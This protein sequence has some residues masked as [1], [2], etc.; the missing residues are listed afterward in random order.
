MADD[1]LTPAPSAQSVQ[2]P[3]LDALLTPE[4]AVEPTPAFKSDEFLK[5]KS[6]A[7]VETKPP[8]P[9]KPQ[10]V[11]RGG[12]G[13]FTAL[14]MSTIAAG[15][16]AYL[17]LLAGSRPDVLERVGLAK[18]VPQAPAAPSLGVNAG[19]LE[20]L[21]ARISAVEAELLSLKT[22]LDGTAPT[23]G[24]AP[25]PSQTQPTTNGPAVGTAVP[26]AP[27]NAD[28]GA[29]KAEL[30]GIAGRVTAI[31][32]RL[33]ALD[34]T[35]AGGAIV[36]GLQADIAAL[37]ATI[38]A[39]QQQAANA[40]SPAVT[41]AV[42]NLA[43][44]ANRPGPFM[45][46]YQTLLAAMP[47]V[48]EVLALEPFARTGVP[49]RELL[50]ERFAGLGTALVEA[51]SAQ[52]QETGVLAWFRGLFAG[53]VK[54]QSAANA[55]GTGSNAILARAKTK[56]D[57]GDFAGAIEDVSTIANPPTAVSDWLVAARKR[58]DLES[59]VSAVRGA[60]GRAVI[61][62]PSPAI[63]TT[64]PTAAPL[65]TPPVPVAKTQGTNP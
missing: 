56:L 6:S 61:S 4:K 46:E 13:F 16:G 20:P 33:A 35:G 37:K 40:P 50:S 64:Q 34:P 22:R 28:A 52:K 47:S 9:V 25:T 48:P 14:L 5:G 30:Q 32:T 36:A 65:P 11:K 59:R 3:A 23:T 2:D 42:V 63:P 10:A 60:V 57:Q 24:P 8:A 44:A 62:P 45:I 26:V 38:S 17:A 51:Q 21:A 39:L 19:N 18:Y 43:E 55:P 31:E 41:F 7:K 53:M 15:A 1:K 49:T 54:V 12:V 29:L 27:P 58:L